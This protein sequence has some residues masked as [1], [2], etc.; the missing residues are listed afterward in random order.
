VSDTENRADRDPTQEKAE[1]TWEDLPPLM[2]ELQGMA[3]RLLARWGN[4]HSLQPTL[5]V[6][7]ALRRQGRKDQ[8]LGEISWESREQLFG[9]V[10]LAMRH[11]LVEYR[12]H[13]QTRGYRAQRRVSVIEM[14]Q[15]EN[16]RGWT[17]DLDMAMALDAALQS[18]EKDQPELAALVQYRFFGGLTREETA[19]MLGISLATVK[20]RWSHARLLIEQAIRKSLGDAAPEPA[21]S[22][23]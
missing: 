6:N 23:D 7:T 5:L 17:E 22:A 11:K 8:A 16:W 4:M 21:S 10:F 12:R 9:Q 2:Q 13:Q 3:K 1:L 14:E 19:E 20:R 18:L 15:Y